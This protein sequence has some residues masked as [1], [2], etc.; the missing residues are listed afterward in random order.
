MSTS[1][2][3]KIFTANGAMMGGGA[4]KRRRKAFFTDTTSAPRFQCRGARD[5]SI[6]VHQSEPKFEDFLFLEQMPSNFRFGSEPR[7]QMWNEFNWSRDK[8]TVKTRKRRETTYFYQ[9]N[10]PTWSKFMA[11]TGNRTFHLNRQTISFS[12]FSFVDD[13][14]FDA[15]KTA[16]LLISQLKFR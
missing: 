16:F 7:K 6:W 3:K 8:P 9:I 11:R 10:N 14:Q 5:A 1:D 4:R 13:R 2:D 15:H 12:T